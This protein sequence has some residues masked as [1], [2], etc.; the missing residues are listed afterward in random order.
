[1]LII[2]FI[3]LENKNLQNNIFDITHEY[4]DSLLKH[5]DINSNNIKI[6]KIYIKN[7]YHHQERIKLLLKE[8]SKYNKDELVCCLN[9]NNII[10]NE[11]INLLEK[12]YKDLNTDQ[13][14]FSS[15][16]LNFNNLEHCFIGYTHKIISFYEKIC[17]KY[18]CDY[19]LINELI[20]KYYIDN[21]DNIIID[22]ENNIFFDLNDKNINNIKIINN[23]MTIYNKKP[24]IIFYK[25]NKNLVNQLNILLKQLNLPLIK[26][27]HEY[28]IPS[29]K[30]GIF[31]L[32]SLIIIHYLIVISLLLTV[33]FAKK[34]S[35]L[36]I[37]LSI[38]ILIYIQWFIFKDCLLTIW[39]NNFQKLFLIDFKILGDDLEKSN[40]KRYLTKYFGFSPKFL[41]K[42]VNLMPLVL[43]IIIIFKIYYYHYRNKK[44]KLK[45]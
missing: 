44:I 1:M 33:I 4:G 3:N 28:V 6:K 15:D 39:E 42:L 26:D 29:T 22:L 12:I 45:K 18:N 37:I 16:I 25:I 35:H 43:C 5:N 38:Y 17:D 7:I 31:C 27:Y 19:I 20:Y 10:F 41:D 40:I 9:S 8:L 14:I 32:Y 23:N 21:K 36:I 30:F 11:N 2:Q 34:L 24:I 13:I